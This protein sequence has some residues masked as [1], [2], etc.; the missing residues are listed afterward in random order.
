MAIVEVGAVADVLRPLAVA[1]Q[2]IDW[3]RLRLV[4]PAATPAAQVLVGPRDP[5]WSRLEL[6]AVEAAW[7]A[8]VGIELS[9]RHEREV[10]AREGESLR[11]AWTLLVDRKPGRRLEVERERADAWRA[12]S[13]VWASRSAGDGRLRG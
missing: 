12:V 13:D 6:E 11:E 4:G 1:R 3:A 8:A 7:K 9:V 5:W 2:D 10:H